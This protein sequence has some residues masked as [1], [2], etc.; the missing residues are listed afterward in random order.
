MH[1]YVAFCAFDL[2]SEF[3]R[4]E[5]PDFAIL[6]QSSKLFGTMLRLGNKVLCNEE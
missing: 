5:P 4:E 6:F 2:S 3:W 1:I